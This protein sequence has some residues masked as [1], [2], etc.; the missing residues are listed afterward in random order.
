MICMP[1]VIEVKIKLSKHNK[2][3][4]TEAKGRGRKK[5]DRTKGSV[6]IMIIATRLGKKEEEEN[7]ASG[8]Y[9]YRVC[10]VRLRQV[11][12]WNADL[13]RGKGIKRY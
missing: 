13:H 2:R 7:E 5:I 1:I 4:G 12:H 6:M 9:T 10:G 8:Y 3:Q 11:D